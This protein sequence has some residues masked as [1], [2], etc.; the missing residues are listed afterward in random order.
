MGQ[1][2]RV[3][4]DVVPVRRAGG[5]T[6]R[7]VATKGAGK[8]VQASTKAASAKSVA[9]KGKPVAAKP[10]ASSNT[11]RANGNAGS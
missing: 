8:P 1:K 6:K 4:S 10:P 7:V 5:S 3:T 9:G 2:V 11:A